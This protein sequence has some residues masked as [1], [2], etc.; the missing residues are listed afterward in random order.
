MFHF[1][2][3]LR[4]RFGGVIRGS[5]RTESNEGKRVR[6][7]LPPL[8]S[9]FWPAGIA[10]SLVIMAL[11]VLGNDSGGSMT[12]TM[13]IVATE[14]TF[15]KSS[16]SSTN[17]GQDATLQV[18]SSPS[19]K[20]ALIRFRV[21]GIPLS[22][23]FESATLRLYVVD[24]SN[25]AGSVHYVNGDWNE[26][27]IWKNAPAI[28]SGI[29][30]FPGPASKGTWKEANVKAA[31][32]GNGTVNFYIITSSSDGVDYASTEAG[33][34]PPT[35]VVKW[36]VPLNGSSPTPTNNPTPGPTPAPVAPATPIAGSG[37]TY[38]VDSASGNDGNDGKSEATAWRT[39][40]KVSNAPLAAGD[41]VL[42]KRGGSWTGK[43]TLSRAGTAQQPIVF[44]A[45]GSGALP[46]IQGGSDCINMTG[47]YLV[48]SNL[49]I[50]NCGWA[51]VEF[52]D[53]A[54]F[55][56]VEN[57]LITGNVAGVYVNGG[58]S[59][60]KVI[61]NTIRDNTKLS[62]GGSG[63]SGAFGVLLNGDRTEVA[64]N[65][66][67]GHDTHS[68]DY[69]RDGAA[70]EVYG[71]RENHVHHNMA[72]NNDA[73]AEL[74][75]SRSR[76][77]TFAYNVVRSSLTESNFVVTRGSESRYGPVANTRLINNS[78]YL[79]GS[80]SQGF[81]CHAGCNS[82]I[83]HMRNNVIHAGWKA[84][85]AD[86]G[87]DEDYGIYSG[88]RVQFTMGPN[89]IVADP[90]F[91]NASAGDLQLNSGS[92]AVDSGAT[93]G[94]STDFDGGTVPH[95]GN[96]DGVAVVDRGAFER[97]SRPGGPVV[98]PAP[99]A[100]A[101]PTPAPT[102][103]P[104]AA[105]A[106]A[107]GP[108][109]P[110]NG[111]VTATAETAP[112]PH[113]GDAAD[114]PAIWVNA[115]DP[116]RSTVIGTDKQGGLGVYDLNGSQLHFYSG[117]KPNN[118]DLRYG[119]NLGGSLIDVVTASEQDS[120]TILVYRVDPS[121]RGLVNVRAQSR[122]TGFGA[123]GL[124]MYKSPVS[125]KFYVFVSDSSGNMRQFE[126]VATGGAI[127]YTQVRT[128][129]FGSV[130]EGCVVDDHHQALYVSEENV[131]LW[132]LSAEPNGG[133][134]M[135]R[136]ASVDGSILTA[137]VEGLAVY[138]KG[139]GTGLLIASSQGSDDFAA[140]DRQS[141]AYRGRFQIVNGSIDGV[142]HTDGIDVTSAPLGSAYPSG[143]FVAQDDRNDSGNQNFKLV[144][145]AG[146]AQAS[147][148]LARQ[149]GP[150]GEPSGMV[151]LGGRVSLPAA[152]SQVGTLFGRRWAGTA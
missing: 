135:T 92:P 68:D 18:D 107:P 12:F 88:G 100:T 49:Q 95:D 43:L 141:G 64:Q 11:A 70:V 26:S 78:V 24:R 54:R 129:D 1:F 47:S 15:V 98:T 120:D 119:F 5:G 124:C 128:L 36:S 55:N 116:S 4:S 114:D 13:P 137:D 53:G 61:G 22:A 63:D 71:G 56:R 35:L 126:L 52:V 2:S 8:R 127:D 145:W 45:Y 109:N 139:G 84:G 97:G 17:Y 110:T 112:V 75:N 9:S 37:T 122:D 79:T 89:S 96:G 3:H 130:T 99:V 115:A 146:I 38:F 80:E 41:R 39:L 85:Y 113:S 147:P 27:T 40:G 108:V 7:R 81:V 101:A 31:V 69:G 33:Q 57:S 65:A 142:T 87:F 62:S 83:L 60:N 93:T 132:R 134:G 103:A 34:H 91:V 67:S 133:S 149:I 90:M 123:A 102:P 66:F 50:S 94:Y 10:G 86:G 125:G 72:I 118:V 143:L 104:T 20:R 23:K 140:F 59:D 144:S 106:P 48:V 44:S 117:I 150:A 21:I 16:R 42:F 148:G 32:T 25:Q 58:A 14:D 51:G 77:N 151:A 6:R 73:F 131:A 121:T 82:G 46:L 136:V 28:G 152:S 29:A 76:D 74:G 105:P 138:D 111:S 19:H 30:A